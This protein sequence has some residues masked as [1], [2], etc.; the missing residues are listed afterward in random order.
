MLLKRAGVEGR[1]VRA[2]MALAVG[3]S[4]I[5]SSPTAVGA[6]VLDGG[7]LLEV[8]PALRGREDFVVAKTAPRVTF[9][10]VEG[11]EPVPEGADG[12][13]VFGEGVCSATGR[14][15]VAFGNNATFDGNCCVYRYDP[16]T[17]EQ[18]RVL[19]MARLL[20]QKPGEFGHGKLHG[21]LDEMPDGWIYM[22]TYCGLTYG[23]L[24]R[25][26]QADFGSRLA[27]YNTRTGL[28]EDLGTPVPG[29][30]YPMNGTDTRR[31]IFHGIGARG[32]YIAYDL[33][34]RR[35]LYQGKLPGDVQWSDRATLIDPKTGR[36][37][38]SDPHTGRIIWYDPHENR[39]GATT[40]RIPGHPGGKTEAHPG[41]RC[42]SRDRLAD[43]S[44]IVQ[45]SGGVMFKFFPDE[46][47]TETLGLNWLDGCYCPAMA[48]S[49]DGGYVYYVPG[50]HDD[51]IPGGAAVVQLELATGRRKV[52]AFLDR[53]VADR[54]GYVLGTSYSICL[55]RE[56]RG[57]L[58][59][60]NGRHGDPGDDAPRL[61]EPALIHLEF[62]ASQGLKSEH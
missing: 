16:A 24:S 54:A 10:L 43:G 32:G 51:P 27:R 17:H 40:A 53:S 50:T 28:A 1:I 6:T 58:I 4:V 31:G 38:S 61:G 29:E 46:Q 55:D 13:T 9:S 11:L 41:I 45:T 12:W 18:R 60:F 44:F 2:M 39:F 62:P 8:P 22:A 3:L 57:L 7:T 26:Q 52:L 56:D 48:V 35:C 47:R 23:D 42:Y 33:H 21:R 25:E 34:A 20:G 49:G 59:A 15:Y 37:Y 30:T 19:D 14:F 5:Y 36:C